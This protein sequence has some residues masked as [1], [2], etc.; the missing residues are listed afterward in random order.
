M[1]MLGTT[2]RRLSIAGALGTF[3]FSAL[4]LPLT[5][6]LAQKPGEKTTT[7][8]ITIEVKDDGPEKAGQEVKSEV[9][10]FV[11]SDGDVQEVIL[12]VDAAR[13]AGARFLQVHV[14]VAKAPAAVP[15]QPDRPGFAGPGDWCT[16]AG[17]GLR[18]E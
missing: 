17:N 6:T 8:A 4:L 2:P 1:I 11:A 10:V 3:G 12:G 9:R 18:V 16:L 5:P 15:E 13:P 14:P 7:Q